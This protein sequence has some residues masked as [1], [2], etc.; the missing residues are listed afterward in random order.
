MKHDVLIIGA[1]VVGLSIA[2]ELMR[3]GRAVT[4]VDQKPPGSQGPSA[5]ASRI[6]RCAYGQSSWYSALTWE[7][8]QLWRELEKESGQELLVPSGVLCLASRGPD[9]TADPEW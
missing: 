5:A 7:S 2:C 6:L 4:V 3:R 9:G 1:G 8:V